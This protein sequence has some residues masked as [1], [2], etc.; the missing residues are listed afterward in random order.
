M[1]TENCSEIRTTSET[2]DQDKEERT[3]E[4]QFT[5]KTQP[6]STELSKRRQGAS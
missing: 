2:N 3:S 4:E 6:W 5:E 1:G